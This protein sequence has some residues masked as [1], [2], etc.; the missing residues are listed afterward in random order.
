MRHG[1]GENVDRQCV[2]VYREALEEFFVIPF[3]FPAVG[4]VGIVRCNGHQPSMI[5]V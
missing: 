3:A 2:R 4:D 5:V 1:V